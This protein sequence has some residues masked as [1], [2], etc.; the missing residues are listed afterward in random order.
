MENADRVDLS[1][2]SLAQKSLYRSV[3]LHVAQMVV[4][5][6]YHAFAFGRLNDRFRVFR[7]QSERF[8]AKR[9]RAAFYGRQRLRQVLVG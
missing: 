5:S 9:V 1:Y 3:A 6:E 8:F 2:R 7:L 4:G